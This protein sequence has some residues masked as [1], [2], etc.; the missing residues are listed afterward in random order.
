MPSFLPGSLIIIVA[1]FIR[2]KCPLWNWTVVATNVYVWIFFFLILLSRNMGPF[3]QVLFS[4]HDGNY[5]HF[6]ENGSTFLRR[7]P[8]SG[9]RY[10]VQLS[11]S[12]KV[13]WLV[14]S[15]TWYEWH[16]DIFKV[17]ILSRDLQQA[18]QTLPVKCY[19]CIIM[20]VFISSYVGLSRSHRW[21]EKV[22]IE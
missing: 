20:W 12:T 11:E 16:C 9:D 2:K 5:Q 21:I 10:R 18:N 1:S 4:I 17:C 3:C 22:A 8:V 7:K 19:T 6:K 13:I 14:E 15:V